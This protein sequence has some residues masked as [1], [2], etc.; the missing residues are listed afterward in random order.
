MT[1]LSSRSMRPGSVLRTVRRHRAG[2]STTVQDMVA[3]EMPVAFIYNG[4]PFAVMMATPEDLEDFALGFLLS[5][6]IVD[7]TH[8]L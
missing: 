8:V 4:V 2:R 5:E 1:S 3:A 6:G 7:H